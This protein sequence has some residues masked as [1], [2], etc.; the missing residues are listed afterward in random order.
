MILIGTVMAV[1]AGLALPGHM[2]LF[3]RVINEFVSY[4]IASNA[5]AVIGQTSSTLCSADVILNGSAFM[6]YLNSSQAHFCFNSQTTGTDP[7]AS[8]ILNYACD[9]KLVLQTNVGR[10]SIYYVVLATGVMFAIF[11]ATIFWNM[12]AYRQTR[13]MRLAFYRS[14]LH[15]EIGWFDVNEASQLNTRLVE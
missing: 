2:L 4:S 9:P 6:Q 13:R 14:I 11:L 15:Q 1:L 10:F 5:S 8:S 3:G 7:I 12:S